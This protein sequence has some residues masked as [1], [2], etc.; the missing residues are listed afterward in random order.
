MTLLKYV[1]SWGSIFHFIYIY[2]PENMIQVPTVSCVNDAVLKGEFVVIIR[3]T[4]SLESN[5]KNL[6]QEAHCICFRN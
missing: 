6:F 1:F 2:T 5:T 4:K 3:T